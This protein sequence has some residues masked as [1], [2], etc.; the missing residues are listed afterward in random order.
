M[1]DEQH[2]VIVADGGLEHALGVVGCAGHRHVQA[3]E[4]GE[5]TSG[6]WEWVA[7]SCLPPPVVV[8]TTSGTVNCPL[9]M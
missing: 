4:M 9:N 1:L 7:P 8:R 6:A 5:I 2:R 3:G